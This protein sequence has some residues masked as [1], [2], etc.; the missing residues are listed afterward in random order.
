MTSFRTKSITV[1]AVLSLGLLLSSCHSGKTDEDV[2]PEVSVQVVVVATHDISQH[3]TADAV[4]WPRAEAAITP[5]VISP[6]AAWYVQR[7]AHVRKGQ[8]LAQLENKDIAAAVQDNEGALQQAQAA[9]LTTTQAGIP[10]EMTK[11]ELEVAQAKQNFDANSK[12]VESRRTLFQQGAIARKDLDAAEVAYVQAKAQYDI[13]AQH[14]NSLQAISKQQEIVAAKGQFT[15]AQGKYAG[16]QAQLSYTQVRSPIDGV[17]TDRPSYVGETPVAGTPLITVM[18]LETIIAKAHVPQAAAQL[19]N[20]GASATISVSGLEKPVKGN[21]TLISPALD[22]NSTTV[23]VWVSVVNKSGTL[24]PGSAAKL[25]ILSSTVKDAIA[26]PNS[27][28]VQSNSGTHV[29][30][31]DSNSIAHETTVQTGAFDSGQQLTQITAG[32]KAGER[33]VTA[34]VYGLPDG[35]KVIPASDSS[36]PPESVKSKPEGQD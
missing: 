14:L 28:L 26:V 32:L 20:V 3:V 16:S 21:V 23:E 12:I 35:A 19:L 34:G 30:V 15:S 33:V 1:L 17:V 24:H 31:V 6:V 2:K 11:A 22:P 29:M 10:E 27:A 9:Y 8:L 18:D 36:A 5:K 25:D 13:S 7:G 4:L